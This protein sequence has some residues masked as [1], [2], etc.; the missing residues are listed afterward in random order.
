MLID[1]L[2]QTNIEKVAAMRAPTSPASNPNPNSTEEENTPPPRTSENNN[3]T[4][5]R[6]IPQTNQAVPPAS[7][8]KTNEPVFG[9]MDVQTQSDYVAAAIEGLSLVKDAAT[10]AGD[11][12]SGESGESLEDDQSHLSNSSTKLQSFDTKSMASVTTFAMDEKESI[13][14]D[15]SASVRAVDDDEASNPPTRELAFHRDSENPPMTSRQGLNPGTSGVTIAPRRY[16]TLTSTNIPRFGDLPVS[17]IVQ[18]GISDEESIPGHQ[19]PAPDEVHERAAQLPVAPDEKLLDA[20]AT[21]KDRL[22]LLQLEETLLAFIAHS[23]TEFLDLPPQN[24]FARL[25]AHK[26]ADYYMLAH[27]INE[28]GTS[29]RLFKPTLITM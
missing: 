20:L 27:H 15:D 6:K 23:Q 3:I 1:S 5:S 29:I 28:D 9:R 8:R 12:Q 13:R 14:P 4:N 2:P 25:L 7:M 18:S 24:A 26:L 17:P 10:A 21:P 19:N 22:P 11:L 16:H